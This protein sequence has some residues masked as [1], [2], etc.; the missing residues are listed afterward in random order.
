MNAM[1][2]AT[3]VIGTCLMRLRR[4]VSMDPRVL[5]S[6]DTSVEEPVRLE[7]STKLT[8]CAVGRGTYIAGQCRLQR[9]R[10]GRF[11]SVGGELLVAAGAHPTSGFASTHPAFFSPAGQAGFAFADRSLFEELPQTST[12]WLVDFGHDVWIGHRVTVLSGVNV[13]TGAVIGAGAVVTKDLS[14]Y[15][16]YAGVP[17]RQIGRRCTEDEAAEL[18]ASAWWERDI[19]WLREHWRAFESIPA[20]LEAL[21][22]SPR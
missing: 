18:L 6:L 7:R 1:S 10:F 19:V 4:G 16:V 14:P 12:G 17:A 20:L 22:R 15:V 2:F 5:V 21:R 8:G 3:H 9:V 11:C 13:G